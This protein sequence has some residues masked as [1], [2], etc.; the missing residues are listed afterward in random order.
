MA[1][2][3]KNTPPEEEQESGQLGKVIVRNKFYQ[4]GYRTL[5]RISIIEALALVVLLICFV[6]Y[7]SMHQPEKRYFATTEDGRLIE[8]MPLGRPNI[9]K[10]ALMSWV[11]QATTE[12]MTF[13]FHDYRRRLQE[14]SRHFTRAGW[15]S[16]TD[17]LES[18]RIIET[19][20]ARQQVVTAVPRSA[21]IL[22]AE[23]LVGGRYQW[24]VQLPLQVTYQSGN[25]TSPSSF[26]VTLVIVRVPKL[27]SPNGIGIAQ[28]IAQQM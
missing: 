26:L 20:K 15:K 17:A 2:N 19:V 13:G 27:E 4:D 23:G 16:F 22:I 21:P 8:M 18:S 24:T 12:T 7:M 1:K 9:G 11:A 3:Q 10:S 5:L 25:K 14:S 6:V 28:W